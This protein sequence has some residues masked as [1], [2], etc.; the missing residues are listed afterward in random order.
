MASF[1]LS[2]QHVICPGVPGPASSRTDVL[3][4]SFV[5]HVSVA[6]FSHTGHGTV[7]GGVKYFACLLLLCHNIRDLRHIRR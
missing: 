1:R 7:H 3:L 6:Y 5:V 2:P 4:F